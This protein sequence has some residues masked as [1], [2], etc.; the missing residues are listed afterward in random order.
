MRLQRAQ[1]FTLIELVAVISLVAILGAVAFARFGDSDNYR[2]V[3][4]RDKLLSELQLAQRRALSEQRSITLGLTQQG[5]RQWLLDNSLQQ[6]ELQSSLSSPNTDLTAPLQIRFN[7][8][9]E[10][11]IGSRAI[12][13]QLGQLALCIATSGYSY[14]GQC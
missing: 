4:A 7:S 13:L 5:E 11:P 1:G 6:I 3:V 10:R 8:V 12:Q 2:Q 14:H 9:G